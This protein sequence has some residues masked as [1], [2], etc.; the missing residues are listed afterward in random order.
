MKKIVRQGTDTYRATCHE[1][2]TVFT[3]ERDDVHHNYVRGGEWVSCPH[4]GHQLMHHGASGTSW[5]GCGRGDLRIPNP[6]SPKN[7][8]FTGPPNPRGFRD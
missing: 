3:Y 6:H 1:C 4:C 8:W 2:G 7:C 5:P